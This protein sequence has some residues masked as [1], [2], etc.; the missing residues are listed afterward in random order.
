MKV[1]RERREREAC[2]LPEAGEPNEV[3]GSLLLG[4]QLEPEL[5]HT[6]SFPL[7]VLG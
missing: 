2:V 1:I 6:P 7:A 3:R 4:G 5:Q